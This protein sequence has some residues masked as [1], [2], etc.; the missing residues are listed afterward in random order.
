MPVGLG[1][2]SSAALGATS[3]VLAVSFLL[4]LMAAKYQDEGSPHPG[5]NKHFLQPE[6]KKRL[7]RDFSHSCTL[8]RKKYLHE[9]ER[10][11]QGLPRGRLLFM[12]FS[13]LGCGCR[14]RQ[15]NPDPSEPPRRWHK[16]GAAFRP[17]L[18]LVR[19]PLA[20]APVAHAC[21]EVMSARWQVALAAA[22]AVS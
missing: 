17:Y 18:G 15:W 22:A 1:S 11:W 6:R 9:G 3:N 7:R 20:I 5:T 2:R 16:W 12:H 19:D 4:G 8:K 14:D 13:G 10:T 21:N